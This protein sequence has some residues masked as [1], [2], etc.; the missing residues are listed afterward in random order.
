MDS[1]LDLRRL[2]CRLAIGSGTLKLGYL[3]LVCL[4]EV[5]T[6]EILSAGF[7]LDLR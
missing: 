7:E 4:F 5:K 2:D 1:E 6:L 3:W